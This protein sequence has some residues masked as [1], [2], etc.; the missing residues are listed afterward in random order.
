M[1]ENISSRIKFFL[2]KLTI[3]ASFVTS[4]WYL[5]LPENLK[6]MPL[7]SVVYTFY[8]IYFAQFLFV[9]FSNFLTIFKMNNVLRLFLENFLSGNFP[10]VSDASRNSKINVTGICRLHL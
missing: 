5:T 1:Y 2:G 3:F 7:V 8:F 10:L 9:F 6:K 4:H